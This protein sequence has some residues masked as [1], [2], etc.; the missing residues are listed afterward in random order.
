MVYNE[1]VIHIKINRA[2]I[3][4]IKSPRDK[5][6]GMRILIS[7][8]RKSVYF[9]LGNERDKPFTLQ[10]KSVPVPLR[11]KCNTCITNKKQLENISCYL[12]STCPSRREPSRWNRRL[13]KS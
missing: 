5:V 13:D 4:K 10:A 7:N 8:E 12:A 9:E 6:C 11:A 1:L 3:V 2:H